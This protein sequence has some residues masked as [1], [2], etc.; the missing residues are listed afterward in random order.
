M[1]KHFFL[2]SLL[3]VIF[4]NK[5]Y[6]QNSFKLNIFFVDSF[7]LNDQND[8]KMYFK[9]IKD[10]DNYLKNQRKIAIKK[11][12]LN[13]SIDTFYCDSTVCFSRFYFGDKYQI[14]EIT[15]GNIEKSFW[16]KINRKSYRRIANFNELKLFEQKVLSVYENN[17]YPFAE[18]YIDS[19][20]IDKGKVRASIF[21]DPHELFVVDTLAV[22]GNTKTKTKFLQRYLGVNVGDVYRANR[23]KKVKDKINQLSYLNVI[24][25]PDTYFLNGKASIYT[26]VNK[27]KNNQFNL[28]LGVLPNASLSRKVTI[29]GEGRLHLLNSF[30]VGEEI[31]LDFKQ[32]K[33]RTQNLDIAFS[34][35]Y[36]INFPIGLYGA[37]NLYKNDTVFLNINSE[38]G[39][40]YRFLG[41]NQAEFFYKN[42]TS[43]MLKVDTATIKSTQSLPNVLDIRN[44]Q[45]GAS[46]RMRKLD[47]VYNPRAGID[48]KIAASVG[49][50][51]IKVNQIIAS[52]LD[53]DNQPLSYLY[54]SLK[55]KGVNYEIQFDLSTYI[56]IPKRGTFLLRNHSKWYI[57]K[58]ILKNQ[59]YRVGG[60]KT[61]RGFDEEEIFT[62]FYSIFTAEFRYLLSKNSYVSAF[63]DI[64]LLQNELL[65]AKHIDVPV[66][67]GIGAS[68]ETKGGIFSLNYALGKRLDNKI[69]FR[70]GK[71]HFGYVTLF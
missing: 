36:F 32:I 27:Q 23:I 49:V 41:Y 54:D 35:P 56:P 5:V 24:K 67:F 30:G 21:V 34:Y 10:I 50:Q 64:A 8:W 68:L 51:K 71:I 38:V 43:N 4:T 55:L 33:P 31:Y 63:T 6:C 70:N 17:G 53:F 13:A 14:D 44:N 60:Y 2:Y 61:L 12:Y 40:L 42:Q 15:N 3:L 69:Q 45:Y 25:D 37:F 66:G 28:L 16:K 46:Y 62:P 59:E 29:T 1:L 52:T 19:L 9:N 57:S 65:G 18:V 58:N 47:Y 7:T 39:V 26:E 20:N 48:W 22:L 11:S